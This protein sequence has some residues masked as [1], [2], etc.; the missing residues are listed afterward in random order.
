MERFNTFLKLEFA[1]KL[2]FKNSSS[3]KKYTSNLPENFFEYL[4]S[5]RYLHIFEIVIDFNII[6]KKVLF[7]Y[8]FPNYLSWKLIN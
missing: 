6:Y 5:G 2:S 7:G 3:V 4:K 8:F 1:V